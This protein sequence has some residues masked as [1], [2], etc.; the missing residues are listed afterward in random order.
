MTW[1]NAEK[2]CQAFGGHLSSIHSYEEAQF[3]GYNVYISNTNFWTGAFSNDGGLTWK[4]SDGTPWNYDPWA[5]GRPTTH[6]SACGMMW[7]GVIGDY[8]CTNSYRV[9]CKKLY[10]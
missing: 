10:Q 1:E 9:I 6:Q 8:P 5:S 3:L 2:Y 7:G 4:W